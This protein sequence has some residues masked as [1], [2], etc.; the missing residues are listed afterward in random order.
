MSNL[1]KKPPTRNIA[2]LVLGDIGRSPRMQY[3]AASLSDANFNVDL[4]GYK[5]SDPIPQIKQ[6]EHI[7]LLHVQQLWKPE[8]GSSKLLFLAWAPIKIVLQ[9]MQL[10]WVFLIRCRR[11]EFILVQVS[12]VFSFFCL[13]SHYLESTGNTHVNGCTILCMVS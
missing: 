7:R 8:Q 9:I 1:P 12:L 2:V 4:I 3:H 13:I 6:A 10:L 11:P 5:G